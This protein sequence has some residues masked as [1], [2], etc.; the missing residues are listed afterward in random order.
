MTIFSYVKV[1]FTYDRGF[2]LS[3]V[4]EAE[5]QMVTLIKNH[6]T[7]KSIGRVQSVAAT[8]RDTTLLDNAFRKGSSLYPITLKLV[9]EINRALDS[10][11]L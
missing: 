4:N 1:D 3:A 11:D 10:G 6:L 5:E 7:D 9:Y 8:L 2:L